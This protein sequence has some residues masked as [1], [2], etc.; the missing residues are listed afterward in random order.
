[1]PV[2]FLSDDQVFRYGRLA[3]EQSRNTATMPATVR[4]LKTASVDDALDL[5]DVLMDT[6]LLGR[7]GAGGRRS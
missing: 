5:L 4:R 2:D 6:R 1:M 7:G 3:A